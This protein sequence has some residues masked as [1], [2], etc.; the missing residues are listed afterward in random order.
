MNSISLYLYTPSLNYL[1]VT[2]TV[3]YDFLYII[4][5]NNSCV[6]LP[7]PSCPILDNSTQKLG[8]IS[9]RRWDIDLQ[10]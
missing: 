10:S 1:L 4:L 5:E 3:P 9:W 8:V 7:N 6:S 2:M